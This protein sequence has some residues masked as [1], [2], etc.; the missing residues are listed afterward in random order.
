MK[1]ADIP[2]NVMDG[3]E[4]YP[5]VFSGVALVAFGLGLSSAFYQS[6]EGIFA[7]AIVLAI[8]LG[9]AWKIGKPK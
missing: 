1:F 5:K 7:M 8:E 3:I 4:K 6:P 2:I 9:V